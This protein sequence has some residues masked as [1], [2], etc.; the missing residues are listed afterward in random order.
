[1]P[2]V[3]AAAHHARRSFQTGLLMA[4]TDKQ[5]QRTANRI[6]YRVRKAT[7]LCT[8]NGCKSP[9]REGRTTCQKCADD[10]SEEK[11]LARQKVK[12][13]LAAADALVAWLMT[14][15]Q[16]TD[17]VSQRTLE[18]AQKYLQVSL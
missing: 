15:V 11:K 2:E 14:T 10:R 12:E 17:T 18:L 16:P 3:R 5:D 6:E 13:Q 8:Q 1:M 4:Y 9:P 7:G